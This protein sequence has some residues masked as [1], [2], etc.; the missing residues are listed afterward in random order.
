MPHHN[1]SITIEKKSHGQLEHYR[2]TQ[3]DDDI[4]TAQVGP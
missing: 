2:A 4:S 1:G 3:V